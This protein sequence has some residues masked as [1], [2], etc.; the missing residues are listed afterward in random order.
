MP[1]ACVDWPEHTAGPLS[2][3]L[4]HA[5]PALL[6]AELKTPILPSADQVV[7]ARPGAK[8]SGKS[9]AGRRAGEEMTAILAGVLHSRITSPM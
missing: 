9:R 6:G 3:L 7:L 8:S 5:G 4:G 1:K 2:L